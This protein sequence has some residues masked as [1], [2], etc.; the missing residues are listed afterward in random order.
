MG[1]T[2]KNRGTNKEYKCILV[3]LKHSINKTIVVRESFKWSFPTI[4]HKYH[5]KK[6]TCVREGFGT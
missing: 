2:Y 4:P 3:E 5:L 6:N 1:R